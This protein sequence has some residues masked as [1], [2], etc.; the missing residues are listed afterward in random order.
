MYECVVQDAKPAI[1]FHACLTVMLSNFMRSP[2]ISLAIKPYIEN[3]QLVVITYGSLASDDLCVYELR[4][5][6]RCK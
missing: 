1:S 5:V 3:S 2:H 6:C 4:R